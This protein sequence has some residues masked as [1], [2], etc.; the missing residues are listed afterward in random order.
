MVGLSILNVRPFDR[1]F[2]ASK[3]YYWSHY[4]FRGLYHSNS[5]SGNKQCRYDILCNYNCT[6]IPFMILYPKLHEFL[7]GHDHAIVYKHMIDWLIDWQFYFS[8]VK[9]LVQLLFSV[10]QPYTYHSCIIHTYR[11]VVFTY[12]CIYT[13]K[14]I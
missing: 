14:N 6:K 7:W 5:P 9:H 2:F 4:T 10:A 13:I 12:V 8:S 11:V 3:L 1:L